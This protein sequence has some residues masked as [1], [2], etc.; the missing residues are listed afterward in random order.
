MNRTTREALE[1]VAV[2]LAIS[3]CVVFGFS[4]KYRRR[5]AI[6]P[7]FGRS[8]WLL[9]TSV[10]LLGVALGVIITASVVVF[11]HLP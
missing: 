3:S 1:I 7:E 5:H 6:D 2:I 11:E 8:I 10:F 9:I 4:I